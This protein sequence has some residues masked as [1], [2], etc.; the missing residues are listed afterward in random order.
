VDHLLGCFESQGRISL[1]IYL[2][3][4]LEGICKTY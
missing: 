1:R 4:R 3:K 2:S